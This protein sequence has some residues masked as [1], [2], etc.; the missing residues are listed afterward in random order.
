MEPARTYFQEDLAITGKDLI[1]MGMK[2]GKQLGFV[3]DELYQA[4]LNEPQLNEKET[5][6]K[7]AKNIYSESDME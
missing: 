1:E 7:L 2:Q 3:L 6:L 5:L 4:V